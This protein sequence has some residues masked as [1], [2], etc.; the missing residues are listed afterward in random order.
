MEIFEGDKKLREKIFSFTLTLLI[1]CSLAIGQSSSGNI[2]GKVTDRN[3]NPL[4]ETRVT[5]TWSMVKEMEA[6]T[7]KGGHF[8]FLSLAPADDY[9]LTFE[10]KGFKTV[11][12]K[13]ISVRVGMN[14]DLNIVMEKGKIEEEI[15]VFAKAP[16]FDTRK[17]A[18]QANIT[19]EAM[20]K[21]PTARD[22]WAL[23]QLAP[24]VMVDRENVGGNELGQQAG[25]V[26]RGDSGLNV[27]WNIEGVNISDPAGEGSSPMY[28]DF[29]MFEEMNIQ[30]AANDIADFT[31]GI[32]INL[33]APRGGNRFSGGARFYITD[34]KF[35]SKNLPSDVQENELTGNKINSIYDYGFNLGGPMI[36]NKLWFW[37]SFGVQNIK[38]IDVTGQPDNSD[39][40][41]YNF[42]INAEWGK[43]RIGAYTF[44]NIKKKDGRRRVGGYLDEP[45]STYIQ[46]G[47]SALF[48]LQDE[49]F[50]SQNFYLSAKVAYIPIEYSLEPKGGRD[51]ILYWDRAIDKWWNTA[52]YYKTR[53]KIWSGELG[54][55][56][57]LERFLGANHEFK[58]GVEYK[59]AV[60]DSSSGFGNGV[61]A[62]LW[63]GIPYEVRFYNNFYE[64]FYA[65]RLS[66][67]VQDIIDFGILSFSVGLRY[68]RQ[69]GGILEGKSSP[70]NVD[71]MKNIQGVDYNWKQAT[72][73]RG[74]FPF[75]WE[76][77]SPR[78]GLVLDLFNDGKTLFK[79]NFSVYGS[80]F[81]ATTAY[82]MFFLY[83]YHRFTWSDSSAD[84]QV[85]ANEL[86]YR[87]TTDLIPLAAK[88]KDLLKEFYD[89]KLTP[90]KTREFLVGVEQ[91]IS[92]D[93]GVEVNFQYRKLYDYNWSK[94]LVYDYLNGSV[95]RQ[96]WDE[97]WV[98]AGSINGEIY[99]DLDFTK[100][101]Y[102]FTD[103]L[104][105]RPDYYQTYWAV[106]LNFK[107]KLTKG[108]MLDGSF[109]YQDHRAH[110]KSRASYQ[111]PT[112]HLPVEK[113]D[114]QP[115][116]YVMSGSGNSNVYL[117][118]RWLG[119]LAAYFVL[120]FGFRLSGTFLAR[121][122]FLSPEYAEDYGYYKYDLEFPWV[123]LD[124]FGS[125]R[126]P[127]LFLVN[128]RLEKEFKIAEFG[129]I[130]LSSDCFNLLNSNVRLARYR[131]RSG[132]NF[133]QTLSIL[134]PRVF[135]LGV[136]FEF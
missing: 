127:N 96:V 98:Q 51:K 113:L 25:F 19:R 109:T 124:K 75:T 121:E 93:F 43:S 116:A 119:K 63:N 118:A 81:D 117:N 26:G 3:G 76:I 61:Q 38:L 83:G 60:V 15:I 13:S 115:M 42:K 87:S 64:K 77:Y 48:K 56:L 55:D 72:Q 11:I 95:V 44:Y 59:D 9:Q 21:L 66:A 2:Y 7:S 91:E 123:W 97:D 133:G 86:T 82:T 50:F 102:T 129:N 32:H 45:E 110:F 36:K 71:F 90:E 67:Y 6:M 111:D 22:P 27:Q 1:L 49:V 126:D 12:H 17:S 14:L 40:T 65:N 108:W 20:Q 88:T 52:D 16:V 41:T 62:R 33:V 107:K 73:A 114:G 104:T 79:A 24:G 125:K 39:L 34:K 58:F 128:L 30:T 68:D 80:Q 23:L 4:P 106:E 37:G 92:V 99:W 120:P 18:I 84:K 130:C 53:R 35:Q 29:D 85:Q 28:Y 112:N 70:T 136:R 131:N 89:P 8:R 47:P 135:R 105:K 69:R 132:G 134:S 57:F 100:V 5:L 94:L 78:I 74:D 31:G 46:K 103:Y 101:G 122:G 54:G 10:R